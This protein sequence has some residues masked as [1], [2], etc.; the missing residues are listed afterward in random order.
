MFIFPDADLG[1]ATEAAARG[2]F[3]NS[4]QVCAA[5]SRL[6][7]HEKLYDRVVEGVIEHAQQDQGWP[8][9]RAVDR[10]WGRWCRPSSASA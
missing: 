1:L 9:R 4:G 8:G 2:I 3:M 7:V 5:G 10:R 6:F